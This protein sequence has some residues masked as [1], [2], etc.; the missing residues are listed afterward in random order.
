MLRGTLGRVLLRW[1]PTASLFLAA[2]GPG[3]PLPSPFSTTIK[4]VIVEVDYQS[5]AQPQTGPAGRFGD[6]WQIF[7]DNALALFEDTDKTLRVESQLEAMDELTDIQS[8]RFTAADIR[9]IAERHRDFITAGDRRSYYVVFLNGLFVNEGK[10][11]STVLGVTL[12]SGDVIALFK[13]VVV[14]SSS[15]GF[16]EQ[17]TLV[18][19]FGHAIGLV[20]NG[21]PLTSPHHDAEHGAHCTNRNCVMYYLN[22]GGRDVAV[23]INRLITTGSTVM[24]GEECL[25]DARAAATQEE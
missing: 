1:L 3:E 19:E 9:Q 8:E 21:I 18:H 20:N 4:D 7:A 22:E 6:W 11:Q 14:N 24:F 15:A 23:F 2:C 16:V 10:V 12:G 25:A 17:A 5:G 13:P